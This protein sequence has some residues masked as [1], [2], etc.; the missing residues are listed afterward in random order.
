MSEHPRGHHVDHHLTQA[1]IDAAQRVNRYHAE[2]IEAR[3]VAGKAVVPEIPP[4]LQGRRLPMD[5]TKR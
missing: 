4:L 5:V 1:L 3:M 2:K